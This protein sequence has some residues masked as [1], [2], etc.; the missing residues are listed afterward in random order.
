MTDG[1][2]KT[3]LGMI[4][5]G[6]T[7]LPVATNLLARGHQVLGY[8]RTD[9]GD[10]AR[11]GG[12]MAR[13]PREIAEQCEVILSVLPSPA[14]LEEVMSGPDGLL[15]ALGPQHTVIEL[16]SYPLA[17]KER[18]RRMLAER[19]ATL[20]DGEIS[21]TPAMTAARAAVILLAG[22]QAACEA[23]RPICQDA[24]DHAQY[25]GDFG[26]ATK[27]KLVANHLVAVHTVAAA[28]ALL[29]V[30]RGGLDVKLAIEVLGLG[31]GSSTM[32]KQRAG[33]MAARQ[34]TDPAPGPVG[35]LEGYLQPIRDL[36]DSARAPTPLFDVAH[37]VFR[38]ALAN[39]RAE[40]DIGCVIDLLD[41]H[42]AA[43]GS[44][45]SPERNRR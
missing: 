37:Q 4:G 28:E 23:V 10:L 44:T 18:Y 9:T 15:A 22:D 34:F 42:A 20:I 39:G 7:G 30:E 16:S 45:E 3:R 29:L 11:A 36:G 5:L 31:A 12:T 43:A 14:A 35:M 33:R 26:A 17:V 13:R 38:R 21:G 6:R 19:G 25:V 32:W 27:L 24:T 8:R 1:Q 40:H 2:V 41:E